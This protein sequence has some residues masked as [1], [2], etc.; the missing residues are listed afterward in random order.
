MPSIFDLYLVLH[1]FYIVDNYQAVEISD[2]FSVEEIVSPEASCG[3]GGGGS[4]LKMA[5]KGG[6]SPLSFYVS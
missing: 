4:R 1:L 6:L 5:A 3:S 2:L